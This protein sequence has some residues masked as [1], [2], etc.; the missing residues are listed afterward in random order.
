MR[1]RVIRAAVLFLMLVGTGLGGS[2]QA[3]AASPAATGEAGVLDDGFG[4]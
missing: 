2:S 4:W 1:R 3:L